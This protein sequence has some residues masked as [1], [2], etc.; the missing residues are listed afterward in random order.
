MLKRRQIPINHNNGL[1]QVNYQTITA[2]IN[3][4]SSYLDNGKRNNS[5]HNPDTS[6]ANASQLFDNSLLCCLTQAKKSKPDARRG[7]APA[8]VSSKGFHKPQQINKGIGEN[9]YQNKSLKAPFISKR[10]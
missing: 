9:I 2:N 5:A 10:S 6:A 7:A 1:N 3:G 8:N 4:G